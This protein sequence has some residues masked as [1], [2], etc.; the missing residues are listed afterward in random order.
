LCYFI[1]SHSSLSSI[2]FFI[3]NS[4]ISGSQHSGAFEEDFN[5]SS[6][7]LDSNQQESTHESSSRPET[8]ID[9]EDEEDTDGIDA[10]CIVCEKNCGDIDQ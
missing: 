2:F 4:L 6:N 1:S 9:A 8:T 3:F 5:A 7:D 10:K